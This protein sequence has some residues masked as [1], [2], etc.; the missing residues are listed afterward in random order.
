[1]YR[2]VAYTA[3][4]AIITLTSQARAEDR[5]IKDV[6]QAFESI[7]FSYAQNGYGVDV[8][9][10]IEQA[11]FKFIQRQKSGNDV[12]YSDTVQLII[13]DRA[14]AFGI[15]QLPYGQMLEWTKSWVANVGLA[16]SA[17]DQSPKAHYWAWAGMGFHVRLEDANL[18]DGTH[19]TGLI[20][21]RK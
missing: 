14:C 7:C 17:H 12:Y 10:L 4:A 3:I 21:V 15:A 9:F 1:M 16:D 6:F 2:R 20:L 8:S 13:G 19:L 18:P 5:N 11:G